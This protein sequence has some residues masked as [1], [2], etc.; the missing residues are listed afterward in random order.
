MSR[1][2]RFAALACLCC[3]QA[4]ADYVEAHHQASVYADASRNSDALFKV[5]VGARLNLLDSDMQN[6]YYHVEDS[7]GQAGWIYRSLVRRRPGPVP[8]AAPTAGR[9]PTAGSS[10]GVPAGGAFPASKCALPYNEE[11]SAAT[12]FDSSCGLTGSA[13][14]DSG[15]FPQN[16]SKND[17]CE[18]AAPVAVTIADLD[19]LQ[20]LVN[21]SGLVF[22]S[23]FSGKGAPKDR[24]ILQTLPALASGLK[25]E[26]GDIV[27]YVGFLVE[28]HYMPQSESKPKN[29]KGGETVNCNSTEH[30]KADI[31]LA[32]SDTKGRI[33]VNDPNRAQKLCGTISAEMIPHLRPPVWNMDSLTQLM[34]LNRPVRLAGH[35]FFDGSHEPCKNGQPHGSDPRRIAEWEIHPVYTLEVCR[36]DSVNKCDPDKPSSW[37]PLSKATGI[38][39]QGEIDSE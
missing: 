20:K 36:F 30:A 26:E 29:G 13:A 6:G 31:H 18:R 3:V 4:R 34:D 39:L 9:S 5:Q 14:R 8:A 22:G 19:Q 25:L 15:E 7:N 23:K 11:A 10:A 2:I 28:A 35:L 1:I 37:Q 16:I 21:A 27:S 33:T 17:L 24:S 12:A 38:D 32:L